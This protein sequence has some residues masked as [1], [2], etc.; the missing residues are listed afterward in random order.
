VNSEAVAEM[1]LALGL[2]VARRVA[3]LDRQIRSGEVVERSSFLGL[4]R[5]QKRVG[6][7]GMG[8]VGTRVA[9]K[10]HGA[11]DARILAYDPHVA[12]GAWADLPH[13]RVG[14]LEDLLPEVDLLTLHLPLTAETRQLIGRRELALMRPTA[15]LVNTSR[16]GIVDEAALCEA[17]R[18][19]RL[20]GAGL[21]VFETEPP[22]VANPL[23]G[24]P[25][26]V[27][28]PHAAGG[29]R[30]NQERSSRLAAQQLLDVLE[31]REPFHRLV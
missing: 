15:I 1:A 19:G 23:V 17:L 9:R 11:F 29:T 12:K 13:E 22:T 27:A 18:S 3:E 21:D 30:E 2:A 20:F 5:W 10:W 14:S 4:E 31:G 26:V 24:L 25:N 16:G 7:V 8:N 28:T 6:V